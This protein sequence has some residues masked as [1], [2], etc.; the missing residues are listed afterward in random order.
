[1]TDIY[2]TGCLPRIDVVGSQFPVFEDK[3]IDPIPEKEWKELLEIRQPLRPMVKRIKRQ[4]VGSCASHATAQACEVLWNSDYGTEDWVE[5]SPMSI[6][7]WISRGPNSGSTIGDNMRRVVDVG[8]LPVPSDVNRAFLQA[9][10]LPK[11]HVRP[12]NDYGG[13]FPTGWKTTAGHF[14]AMEVF[15]IASW[16]GFITAML[17]RFPCVA[18][19]RGHALCYLD[20]YYKGSRLY[21]GG[22][23][24][25]GA[26]WGDAGFF[27]DAETIIRPAIS[28]YG[29]FAIR[30]MYLD[31]AIY[32][33]VKD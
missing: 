12:E 26:D 3:V 21:V 10:G 15:D 4:T 31:D 16:E 33:Q 18:G 9:V 6:Y 11:D 5:L 29:A 13:K 25:W 30:S 22:A 32:E 14:K 7:P 1:M 2:P 23:N 17:M 19:R 8:M 24:S 27:E 28:S 20:P